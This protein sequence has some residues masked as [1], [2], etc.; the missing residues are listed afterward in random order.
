MTF[1]DEMKNKAKKAASA[2][3]LLKMAKA[4]GVELSASEAEQYYNF[5]HGSREMTDEE[6][7]MVAGGKGEPNY[8]TPK[9]KI[10]QY[11]R[12]GGIGG[13]LYGTITGIGSYDLKR[14]YLYYVN[15]E[16][17][18]QASRYLEYEQ[19]VKILS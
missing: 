17:H 7:S 6:L 10:G 14:G 5:L 18:G 2:E 1:T 13:Y 19:T 12:S 16:K 4:E 9:Y 3:E 15:F 8:P 11:F